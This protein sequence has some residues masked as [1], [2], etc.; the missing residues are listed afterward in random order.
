MFTTRSR[1]RKRRDISEEN[2]P[3]EQ[4]REAEQ[5]DRQDFGGEKDGIP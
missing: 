5:D 1:F 3:G 2:I 4:G